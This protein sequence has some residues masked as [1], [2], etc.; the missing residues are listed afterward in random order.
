MKPSS[1]LQA[2]IDSAIQHLCTTDDLKAENP[3][4]YQV[5]CWKF[6]GTLCARLFNTD[7]TLIWIRKYQSVLKSI[8]KIYVSARSTSH[9]DTTSTTM[10]PHRFAWQ[11]F[12]CVDRML[13]MIKEWKRA[14]NGKALNYQR[15]VHYKGNRNSTE[16]VASCYDVRELVPSER[17]ITQLMRDFESAYNKLCKLLICG[18]AR[19]W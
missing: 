11:Y 14:L 10:P 19:S 18:S 12:T 15:I 13:V 2:A 6:I 8:S 7:P 3:T 16:I 1:H 5:F 17:M 9:Q 4:H